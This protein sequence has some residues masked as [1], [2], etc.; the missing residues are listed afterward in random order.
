MKK[1]LNKKETRIKIE[2]VEVYNKLVTVD[3]DRDDKILG[4]DLVFVG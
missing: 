4:F 1:A 2:I 3:R